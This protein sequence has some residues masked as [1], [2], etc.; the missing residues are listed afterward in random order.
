MPNP[1][2]NPNTRIEFRDKKIT[3]NT[4]A[5]RVFTS[6]ITLKTKHVGENSMIGI[7]SM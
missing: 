5:K 1:H 4:L 2:F 6:G 7:S 3:K